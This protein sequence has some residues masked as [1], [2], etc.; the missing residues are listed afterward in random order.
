[1]PSRRVLVLIVAFWLATTGYAVYR[2][3]WPR[4]VASGPPPF[5]VDL[6]DEARPNLTARWQVWRGDQKVGR[7]TTRMSYNDADD[8]FSFTHTYTNLQF[9]FGKVRI[10]IPDLTNTTRVSRSGD[11]RGESMSGR[12]VAPAPLGE[13]RAKVEGRVENGQFVGHCEVHSSLLKVD[14][15][16]DPVPVAAGQ[17]FNPL[18]PLNRI[19][20]LRPGQRWVVREI[21]PLQE[22]LAAVFQQKVGEFGFSVPKQDRNDLIAEVGSSPQ[23]LSWGGEDVACWVIEYRDSNELKARTWV[24]AS[25]GRVLR[26]EAFHKGE[27][28]ALEREE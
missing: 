28:M 2:D 16:L 26:Q 11:L 19:G 22:A 15:D 12:M 5:E 10:L 8:T 4:L 17:V 27:Q 18:Q 13:G 1:M 24:R 3:L 23:T 20:R 14:R 6:A 25:D 7:L 9:D 21:N